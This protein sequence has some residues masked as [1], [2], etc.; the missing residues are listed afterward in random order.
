MKITR[1]NF[2]DKIKYDG[3]NLTRFFLWNLV[4]W[5]L[6]MFLGG[7]FYALSLLFSGWVAAVLLVAFTGTGYS[8]YTWMSNTDR[9]L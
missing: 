7:I 3:S 4:A 5:A 9:L 8:V 1:A 2:R 6:L